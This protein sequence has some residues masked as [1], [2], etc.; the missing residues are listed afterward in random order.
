MKNR[1][2]SQSQS[3]S[4]SHAVKVYRRFPLPEIVSID[5][6]AA[7]N[8]EDLINRLRSLEEER[9][10]VLDAHLDARPWEEEVAYIR[11]ELQI[12]RSRREAHERYV[13]EL[14]REFA[15]AEANLPVADL[16]NSHFLRIVGE[17]N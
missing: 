10:K 15:E 17:I 12:R 6:M 13:R 5:L 4:T 8:D 3:P 9:N 16:D 7:A 2:Q 14:E 1:K 11:R